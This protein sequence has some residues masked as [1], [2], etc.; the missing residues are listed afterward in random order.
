M[1]I[2][3]HNFV[4]NL[5]EDYSFNYKAMLNTFLDHAF[6]IFYN[7]KHIYTCL[8]VYVNSNPYN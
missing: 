4:K 3:P 1:Y 8:N 6:S 2:F 5:K 7:D